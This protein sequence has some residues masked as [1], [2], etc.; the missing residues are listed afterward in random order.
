MNPRK[1]RHP[2]PQSSEGRISDS[3][4]LSSTS[5]SFSSLSVCVSLF[6]CVVPGMLHSL[7]DPWVINLVLSD[8]PAGCCW[9]ASCIHNTNY[10]SPPTHS[11]GSDWKELYWASMGAPGAEG[12][13]DSYLTAL[14]SIG[15][16]WHIYRGSEV[17]YYPYRDKKMISL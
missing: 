16:D 15:W 5:L 6:P 2:I 7:H 17:M 12:S 8:F 10:K 14:L 4:F 1:H 3:L 11:V 13:Q 9:G